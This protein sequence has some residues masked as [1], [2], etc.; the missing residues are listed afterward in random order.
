MVVNDDESSRTKDK[1]YTWVDRSPEDCLKEMVLF[2]N[3]LSLKIDERMKSCVSHAAHDLGK[4]LYIPKILDSIQ[5]SSG[6]LSARKKVELDGLG[7]TEFHEFF[8]YVCTLPHIIKVV[9]K[10]DDAMFL[11]QLAN[12]VFWKFKE[13]VSCVGRFGKPQILLVSFNGP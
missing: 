11:P 8:Q 13:A 3:A 9:E 2:V 5:G 12:E 6:R 10:D 4:C 1:S 7:K